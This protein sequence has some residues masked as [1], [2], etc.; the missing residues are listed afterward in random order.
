MKALVIGFGHVGQ[1]IAE[2][3]YIEKEKYPGLASLDL[4]I[5][6][7]YT[8]TRGA[9]MDQSGIDIPNAIRQIRNE[10]NFSRNNPQQTDHSLMHAIQRLDYDLLIELSTLSITNKGEP[11]ISHIQAALKRGKHVVT[12]NKGPVAFAYDELSTIAR[13]NSVQFRFEST[14]MD[15]TPLFSLAENALKGATII[16]LSGILNSTTNYILSQM[17]KGK[18][19]NEALKHA[20]NEGFAEADPAHDI[21][22]WDSAAK[23]AVL[24]NILM[25]ANI[26]PHDVPR[27]G[28]SGITPN[29]V[30]QALRSGNCIKLIC[31][32][33]RENN[34]MY[35]SV[36]PEEIPISDTFAT[37]GGSGAC[38]RIETDLMSPIL[39][40]QDSPTVKDT[41]YGVLNDILTIQQN[42]C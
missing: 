27:K 24:A 11:A 39:I 17:E 22:G 36:K 32:A 3:V 19:F 16:R 12:A 26:T 35:T 9:L 30:N 40:L 14:V 20:Q 38:L 1:K 28:I 33:W 41:A 8:K 6:G 13:K 2:I 34:R 37:I 29:M 18:D 4:S 23:I 25:Q 10:G 21:E 31:K 5:M 15:G 7:L 42:M